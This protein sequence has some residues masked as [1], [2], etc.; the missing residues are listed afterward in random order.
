[1]RQ[2]GSFLRASLSISRL[3]ENFRLDTGWNFSIRMGCFL[4]GGW[5]L[6]SNYN[7][8]LFIL[9]LLMLVASHMKFIT[10]GSKQQSLASP[11]LLSAAC[12]S[13]EP[14]PFCTL[15]LNERCSSDW[16]LWCKDLEV[17]LLV[18]HTPT[19]GLEDQSEKCRISVGSL[20]GFICI[21]EPR[22]RIEDI[23]Q[24]LHT[25]IPFWHR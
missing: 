12:W 15:L 24:A 14:P 22:S 5:L 19:P 2:G 1:M 11:C 16:C 25:E 23:G 7:N 20:A 10:F 21:F 17:L 3:G 18:S 9:L 13:H 8:V 4:V 6:C